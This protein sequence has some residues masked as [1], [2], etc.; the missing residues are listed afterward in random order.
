MAVAVILAATFTAGVAF[1]GLAFGIQN[2]LKE[3]KHR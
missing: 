1:A 2:E 3:R